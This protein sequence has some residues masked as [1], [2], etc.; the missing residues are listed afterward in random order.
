MQTL[1]VYATVKLCSKKEGKN[2]IQ[3]EEL[4]GLGVSMGR[5]QAYGVVHYLD[6][7]LF[8]DY[9]FPVKKIHHKTISHLF[10]RVVALEGIKIICVLQRKTQIKFGVWFPES[11]LSCQHLLNIKRLKKNHLETQINA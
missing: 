1:Q 5:T 11:V 2:S 9:S 8:D 6:D 3:T 4:I 10:S 7:S